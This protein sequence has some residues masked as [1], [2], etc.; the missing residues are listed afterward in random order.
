MN[1]ATEYKKEW[2]RKH[3]QDYPFAVEHDKTI[4]CPV[5]DQEIKEDQLE[6]VE[7]VQTKRG[8]KIFVHNSCV[9]RW[10]E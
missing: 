7:F 6:G 1:V 9:K 5:C 3:E 8:T 2:K 10:S 4:R